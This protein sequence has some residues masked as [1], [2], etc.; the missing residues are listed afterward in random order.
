MENITPKDM[1][2]LQNENANLLAQEILPVLQ[3]NI[4]RGELN[5]EQSKYLEL[6]LNWNKRNDP[7]EEGATVF[8]IWMESLP[9]PK[10]IPWQKH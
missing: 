10:I 3:K 7:D 9:G 6:V 1:M 4:R 2:A 5:E 8:K